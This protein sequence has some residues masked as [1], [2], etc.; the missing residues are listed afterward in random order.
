MKKIL[1]IHHSTS[2]GGAP[3]SLIKLIN[4]LDKSK[5]EAKV[6]LLRHSSIADKLKENGIVFSIAESMF[7]K[8]FYRFF[9]H[10]E[11]SYVKW[12]QIHRFLRL[13]VSWILS[14]LY[15]ARKELVKHKF[16]IVHLNSSVLTDWLAPVKKNHANA[17][18]H[19][20]EPFR[21]GKLDFLHLFFKSKI[22]KHAD[23]IIAISK[24]N[25]RRLD[26]PAKTEI[27]Y[28]YSEIPKIEP[29]DNS[30]KS[31]KVLYMGGSSTSKGFY[32][33]VESL[34]YLDENV[35]VFFCGHYSSTIK[36]NSIIHIFKLVLSKGLKRRNA[37]KKINSHPNAK[38]FGLVH[39]VH[40][41][42]IEV[43]CHVSPFV[44]PHFSRPV[45]EAH[46]HSKP[47]IGTD[48]GGMEEII[49]HEKNGL[50][51]P[52]NNPKE[53]AMAINA[54]VSDSEKAKKFGRYGYFIAIQKFTPRNV[55]QFER[56]YDDISKKD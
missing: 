44:V 32:T 37:I 20:R 9:A 53:L 13:G 19:I 38:V 1:Y 47:V 11:E 31:G 12:Y 56:L 33:L 28:N 7:Y 45:I 51:V 2:W 43:C 40:D 3:N 23:K 15:F 41:L 24:D 22:S 50:I 49:E 17:I 52:R 55:L 29:S 36:S 34:D 26:I 8:K 18:I 42:Y 10:S 6:L 21:K 35:K 14:N 16:D 25:A 4:S 48:V 54:L 30:Y 5:Y 27:I 39:N 46:L